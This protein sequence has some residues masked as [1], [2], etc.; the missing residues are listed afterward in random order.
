MDTRY[1]LQNPDEV[2]SPGLLFYPHIIQRNIERLNQ[3]AG[4]VTHLRPH[5]KTH[6]TREIARMQMRSGVRKFK[7]A[8]IAEA[9]M[10]GEVGAPDA[11]I[12]YQLVG[13]NR[14]RLVKLIRRFPDTRFSS[15]LDNEESA[16][17]LSE[18]A[19]ASGLTAE[20]FID[21][22]V[23][24]HRTGIA[25][26]E[27]AVRLY[28]LMA[29]LPGLRPAGIHAYDGHNHQT[30]LKERKAATDD[31]LEQVHELKDTV[32]KKGLPVSTL[33]MGGTPPLALYLQAAGVEASPG[34]YILHDA[35]YREILPDLDFEPAALL[36]GRVISKPLPAHATVDIGYKAISSDMS[37]DRGLVLDVE[38]PN[39]EQ[40]NEEH[41]VIK[42]ET[43]KKWNVGQE[44][45]VIPRHVCPTVALHQFAN[46][47][48]EQGRCVDRWEIRSRP[49]VI[50]I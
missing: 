36:L 47:I 48:D 8:T 13:P 7:C 25:P 35:Q 27:G 37:G 22:D 50:S 10:L 33:V 16:R 3:I 28:E 44:V 18:V 39:L 32:E 9:E 4:D 43:V 49:R 11:L 19:Q 41:W 31:V 42:S 21:L 34:T 17:Q 5:I 38:T 30:D 12:A 6:K 40:Q 45:Y 20:V 46:V 29:Q 1:I 2:S 14:Q 26:G 15:L 23:G 24:M